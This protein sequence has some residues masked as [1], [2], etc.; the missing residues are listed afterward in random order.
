MMEI[1]GYVI[2][3]MLVGY[4]IVRVIF[5][6]RRWTSKFINQK[7]KETLDLRLKEQEKLSHDRFQIAYL[8]LEKEIERKFFDLLK[9]YNSQN[10]NNYLAKTEEVLQ[11]KQELPIKAN[12]FWQDIEKLREVRESISQGNQENY[13]DVPGLADLPPLDAWREVD[14]KILELENSRQHPAMLG[15]PE[16]PKQS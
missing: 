5:D 9:N 13:R 12:D 7:I 11:T 4:F 15:V 2:G 6:V 10:E 8:A 14:A 1:W 3:L 16:N